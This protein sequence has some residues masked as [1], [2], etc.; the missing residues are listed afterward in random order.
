MPFAAA[1]KEK[2]HVSRTGFTFCKPIHE[3][4][5]RGVSRDETRVRKVQAPPFCSA[6]VTAEIGLSPSPF[7]FRPSTKAFSCCCGS[8]NP[9]VPPNPKSKPRKEGSEG[10]LEALLLELLGEAGKGGE[11]GDGFVFFYSSSHFL[12]SFSSLP[13]LRMSSARPMDTASGHLSI[14]VF[15]VFAFC[16]GGFV[17]PSAAEAMHVRREEGLLLQ[18]ECPGR[19]DGGRSSYRVFVIVRV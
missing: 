9:G 5:Y 3:H 8:E 15:A 6:H 1:E 16:G 19:E 14:V 12:S 17:V 2:G 4:C 11:A 13:S 10:R 18:A 7:R